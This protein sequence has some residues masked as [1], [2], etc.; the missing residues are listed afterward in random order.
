MR[1]KNLHGAPQSSEESKAS[2]NLCKTWTTQ[3][4]QT[5]AALGIQWVWVEGG[6]F[7]MGSPN[8]EEGHYDDEGPQHEVEVSDFLMSATLVTNAQYNQFLEAMEAQGGAAWERVKESGANDPYLESKFKGARQ[9]VVFVSWEEARAFCVWVGHG[10]TLPTEAQWEYACRA[11]SAGRFCFGEDEAQLGDYAW[12]FENAGLVTHEVAGKKPNAL[13]LYDM[14]GNVWEWCA[15][16]CD[17]EY[18]KSSPTKNPTGPA[19][20]DFRMFRGGSWFCEPGDCRSA[21]RGRYLPW[22]QDGNLGFRLVAPF[23]PKSSTF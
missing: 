6:K 1:G 15:D 8:H 4:P 16:W 22:H 11:G 20:G 12:Y 2:K 13:G 17:E 14:H 18:Y 10:V 7:L 5:D 3:A 19:N 21:N 23:K 9:P